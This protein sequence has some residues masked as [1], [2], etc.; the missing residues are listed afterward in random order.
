MLALLIGA[1]L[2]VQVQS[3]A[4]QADV[5]VIA[6]V[7]AS[8][9]GGTELGGSLLGARRSRAR[10]GRPFGDEDVR[11]QTCGPLNGRPA[12]GGARD[13]ARSERLTY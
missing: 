10:P 4:E 2:P 5:V 12:R 9:R 8:R 3:L 7:E 1:L 11:R 13:G 6:T